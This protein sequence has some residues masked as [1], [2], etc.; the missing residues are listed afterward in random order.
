MAHKFDMPDV[1]ACHGT[2]LDFIAFFGI[3]AYMIDDP[4]MSELL[5]LQQSFANYVSY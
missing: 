5:Y 1:V 3:F 2:P 4:F